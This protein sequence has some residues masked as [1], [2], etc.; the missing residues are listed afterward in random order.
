MKKVIFTIMISLLLLS[1]YSCELSQSSK[2]RR[3]PPEVFDKDKIQTPRDRLPGFYF[4]LIRDQ[5]ISAV[6]ST[7]FT[8]PKVI[9][10]DT[11]IISLAGESMKVRLIG[12]DTPETNHPQKG[13]EYMGHEATEFVRGLIEGGNVTLKLDTVNISNGHL[14]KYDRLL[15][16]IYRESDKLFINEEIMAQGYSYPYNEFP[17]SHSVRFRELARISRQRKFGLWANETEEQ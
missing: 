2:N 11:V 1:S 14:D 3:Q 17:F 12:V 9:D 10:G 13:V 5:E 7:V 6:E 16:Y 4:D 8:V 15:A